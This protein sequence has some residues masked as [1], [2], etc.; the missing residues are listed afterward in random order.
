[1]STDRNE[2][3]GNAQFVYATC[4][5][6]ELSCMLAVRGEMISV[7]KI[8]RIDYPPVLA[9]WEP[10]PLWCLGNAQAIRIELKSGRVIWTGGDTSWWK[11]ETNRQRCCPYCGHCINR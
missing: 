6:G 1:M 2:I 11:P 3:S 4:A 10:R 8:A 9:P 7:D 5:G